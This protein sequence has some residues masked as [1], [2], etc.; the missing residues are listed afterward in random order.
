MLRIP[1]QSP[2][3]Q[4]HVAAER[5]AAAAALV[6]ESDHAIDAR[7]QTG[8]REGVGDAA[9]HSGRT[10][11]AG[12]DADVV[13]RA[14]STVRANDAVERRA[15]QRRRRTQVGP[16]LGL[17]PVLGHGQVVD[18]DMIAGRD[19]GPGA[20]DDLA[21]ATHQTALLHRM[22]GDLVPGVDVGA[23]RRVQAIRCVA[24][25]DVVQGDGDVVGG[26]QDQDARH[27]FT[28]RPG[29]RPRQRRSGLATDR[30]T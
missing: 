11:H 21:I 13:A 29:A 14:D 2:L 26:V 10:V 30:R 27:G 28:P 4:G 9:R 5:R 3:Q 20:A 6:G 7:R 17:A 18:V 23:R 12:Q 25:G 19:G 24:G 22:A 16:D 8:V 15:R 1:R